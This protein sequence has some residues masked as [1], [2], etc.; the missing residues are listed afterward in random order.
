MVNRTDWQMEQLTALTD[1][2]E[3]YGAF[4][5]ALGGT[6][7]GNPKRGIMST[8]ELGLARNRMRESIFWARE[9]VMEHPNG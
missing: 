5:M 6:P 9:H 7:D 4:L 3:A 2:E 1:M 8:W